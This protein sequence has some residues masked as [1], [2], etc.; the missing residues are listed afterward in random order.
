MNEFL[1]LPLVLQS[2]F[3]LVDEFYFH[4]K[5]GLP[6]WERIGHPL[7]TLS[8]LFCFAFTLLTAPT[9]NHIQIF[10]GLSVFSCLFVTKDEFVHAH[11]CGS[12][13]HWVHSVLFILHPASLVTA[14]RFWVTGEY[15]IVIL[16]QTIM[17]GLFLL[18]QIFYWQSARKLEDAKS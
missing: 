15:K 14:Y 13:E 7:D 16:M 17:I 4:I 11:N 1:L 3:I 8:F 9:P 5:R 18:W 6:L 10:L 12:G 2:L